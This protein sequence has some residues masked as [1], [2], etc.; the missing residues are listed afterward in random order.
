MSMT[1]HAESGNV[2]VALGSDEEIYQSHQLR[3]NNP[4]SKTH[5]HDERNAS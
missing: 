5:F 4:K 1:V 2:V 3:P